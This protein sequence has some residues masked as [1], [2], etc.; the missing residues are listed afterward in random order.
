MLLTSGDYYGT[1]AAARCLGRLNIPVW[2]A[3]AP[4]FSQTHWSRFVRE[5]IACPPVSDIDGFV[6]WLV[7]FGRRHSGFFLYSTS[8]DMSW[9]LASRR[10]ELARYYRLYQPPLATI[11]GLLDK[12]RL[13]EACGDVGIDV[14]ETTFPDSV[15]DVERI[16]AASAGP[17]LIKP[18]T[19][20]LLRS[21]S[22]GR[23]CTNPRDLVREFRAFCQENTY[24]DEILA[25][26]RSIALPMLQR[27]HIE[28]M[29][30]TYSLSGFIDETGQV[31]VVRA[32]R[33]VFQRPRRLGVGL[34]F[35]AQSVKAELR[36]KIF[37]LCRKVGYYGAFESEFVPIGAT[38]QH[39][40]I[41]FN[42]RFYGQ[43][44][45]EVA[46]GMPLP[47]L[48]YHAAHGLSGDALRRA[49]G[50]PSESD[51]T[52]YHFSNRWILRLVMLTQTLAGRL[53]SEERRSLSAILR[54]PCARYVDAV[55]DAEDSGPLLA[56]VLV[57]LGHFAR[58]PRDFYRKF[59]LD[60]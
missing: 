56:D 34:C 45:L 1:L 4:T 13:Y 57:N 29:T 9:V 30:E 52:E 36:Q 41:D 51:G 21:K 8:D 10:E 27:Y 11:V 32:A 42:P 24:R 5:T 55:R 40:L 3:D 31:F 15:K 22:K 12:R 49:V 59:F 37:E 23:L 44:G 16:A 53:S 58:H 47:A 60:A 19:Q 39:K 50:N 17:L 33:K 35:L 46:R 54:N 48:V 28:A 38:G 6:D 2:L 26:D 14:P 7:G 20:M 25:L 43:M 18:R